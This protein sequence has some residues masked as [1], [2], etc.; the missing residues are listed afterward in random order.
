MN[1]NDFFFLRGGGGGAGGGGGGVGSGYCQCIVP[2]K[3]QLSNGSYDDN[4][5]MLHLNSIKKKRQKAE[6]EISHMDNFKNVSMFT[7]TP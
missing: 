5:Y 1:L 6:K 7:V 3:K 2:K 4:F